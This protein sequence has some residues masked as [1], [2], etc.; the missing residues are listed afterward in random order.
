MD[1]EEAN[2]SNI[3][4]VSKGLEE[5]YDYLL[6][7]GSTF[8]KGREADV[9]DLVQDVSLRA[10]QQA[11][12]YTPGTNIKAWLATVTRNFFINKY[13][14]KVK[15]KIQSMPNE[16]LPLMQMQ[17][18]PDPHTLLEIKDVTEF[19]KGKIEDKRMFGTDAEQFRAEA[20]LLRMEGY[21]YDEI[22]EQLGV[23]L[24]T[25]KSALHTERH[26]FLSDEVYGSQLRQMANMHM[27]NSSS[28]RK[29][30]K[31]KNPDHPNTTF[32]DFERSD[33]DPI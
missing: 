22:S 21:K 13:R 27:K 15:G 5:H 20:S 33:L 18:V 1:Q 23:P 12:H 24:G 10:L 14:K 32:E 19:V 31:S 17:R 2:L 4:A 30:A 3:E 28:Y 9:K 26:G 16:D 6:T 29:R 11:R 7:L 25:V 8:Y